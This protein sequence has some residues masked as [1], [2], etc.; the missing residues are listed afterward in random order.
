MAS[1]AN[2]SYVS[3]S[4]YLLPFAVLTYNITLT[5][6]TSILYVP[7]CINSTNYYVLSFQPELLEHRMLS[8]RN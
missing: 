6:H 8:H 5:Y 1:F 4:L 7:L 3:L 2:G